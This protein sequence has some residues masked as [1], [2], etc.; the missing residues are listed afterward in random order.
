M[1]DWQVENGA[2]P[3]GKRLMPKIPFVLGGK[4]SLDNIYAL[5]SVSAMKSRGNL[6]LQLR[7][8]PDGT[9]VEF[10]VVP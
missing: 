8:L 3:Q 1:H 6:A 5:D 4:Y 9:K 2:I 10:R 7:D